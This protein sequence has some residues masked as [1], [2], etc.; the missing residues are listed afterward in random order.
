[1]RF[2][3]VS[4]FDVVVAALLFRLDGGFCFLF[5]F[6]GWTS[7]F[8]TPEVQVTMLFNIL[9][10]EYGIQVIICGKMLLFSFNSNLFVFLIY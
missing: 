5:F 3:F 4:R 7:K 2:F 9:L 10:S 8:D 1:M 6:S